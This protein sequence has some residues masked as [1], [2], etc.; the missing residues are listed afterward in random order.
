MKLMRLI[1]ASELSEAEFNQFVENNDQIKRDSLWE[2]GYVFEVNGEICG[3]FQLD[4]FEPDSY[5][6]KQLYVTKANAK[7]LPLLL[8]VILLYA[9]QQQAKRIYAH[10]QQP[11]TDLLLDSF[12]F[13]L[14]QDEMV[15]IKYDEKKLKGHWWLYHVS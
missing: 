1:Q 7:K 15:N 8:E 3:C 6:L 2:K 14:Q 5:W 12:S 4:Q 10:S 9:K 13:S 11:V